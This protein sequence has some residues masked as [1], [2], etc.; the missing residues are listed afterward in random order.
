MSDHMIRPKQLQK[1]H[2]KAT[3]KTFTFYLSKY[4]SLLW[5]IFE[6]NNKNFLKTCG[7]CLTKDW[8]IHYQL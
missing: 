1:S 2:T 4:D 7:H 8:E 5:S 6:T 3:L